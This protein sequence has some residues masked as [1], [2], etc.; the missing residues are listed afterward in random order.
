MLDPITNAASNYSEIILADRPIGYW[1]LDE[2]TG[3]IA[4]DSSGK[5]HDGKLQG[6]VK[7]GEAGV[8]PGSRSAG[9]D[10]A[11]GYVELPAAVWGG[12]AEIT[13]EAWMNSSGDTG[14]LQAV[15]SSLGGNEF[16]HLQVFTDPQRPGG[17]WEGSIGA[18]TD[19]G[20]THLTGVPHTPLGV[21]RHIALVASPGQT[22]L[23]VDGQVVG[24]NPLKYSRINPASV[25]HIGNG[26]QGGRFFKGQIGEVAVYDHA[27][28][29][30]R[31]K[32][33]GDWIKTGNKP[34]SL[35]AT[36]AAQ[37]EATPVSIEEQICIV[38]L[39]DAT[40]AAPA[41]TAPT[42]C[43]KATPVSIEDELYVAAH[44]E[45]LVSAQN[46]IKNYVIGATALGLVPLPLVDLAAIMALQVKLVHGLA[47]HYEVPFKENLARSLVAS[48]LSGTISSIGFL[49]L[50]SLAK[51]VPVLGAL[52]GTGGVAI[53][54]GAV[55]YGVGRV[56]AGHFESGG[57]LMDFNPK[58]R[59]PQF[60]RELRK[61]K[62]VAA[63]VEP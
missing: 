59:R 58:K 27:L 29:P 10:G 44:V 24:T 3:A 22:C 19:A 12:G 45:R 21:W 50:A 15:V 39:T 48:L 54:G 28:S 51:S 61:G 62:Q 38:A 46:L 36:P 35:D 55:T 41:E 56:F 60:Q 53:A 37:A 4:K 1:K 33:R 9:F 30:E 11:T 25:I 49:G 42:A 13:V 20:C 43:A 63:G 57:T 6:G 7:P 47:K 2:A 32:L 18:F 5:G 40:T 16:V 14:V 26:Y 52:G 31:I 23:Y 17:V 8:V 34:P